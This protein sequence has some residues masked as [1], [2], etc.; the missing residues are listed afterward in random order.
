MWSEGG[1]VVHNNMWNVSGYNVSEKL[2]ACS[3]KSWNVTATADNSRGDGAVK[4]Y[5]NVHKDYHDWGSGKEP[6]WSSFKTLN[7]TFA[8]EG[9]GTGIYDIAYDIWMNG[10]PGNREIMIWTENRGQRPAGN[11]VAQGVSLSGIT[12]DVWATGNNSYLAF[13]PRSPLPSGS[14]DLKA[15]IDLLIAQGR[16]PA[17][18]TLGQICFGVEV[19]STDG[20]PATFHFTDFSVTSS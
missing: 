5:P 12:W 17:N 11:L 3:H 9:S 19:V 20:K 8:A 2:D 14:L 6:A 4:T 16:I 13:V 7:S 15:M 18:S 1:Y 10:V